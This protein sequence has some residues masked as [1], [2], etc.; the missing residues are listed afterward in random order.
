MTTQKDKTNGYPHD[1]DEIWRMANAKVEGI[2]LSEILEIKN[3]PPEP[4]DIVLVLNPDAFIDLENSPEEFHTLSE[5][6]THKRRARAT[7]RRNQ[8]LIINNNEGIMPEHVHNTNAEFDLRYLEKNTIKLEPHLCTCIDLK[9]ALKI[10]ATIMVQ[11][12][13]RSS[14]AKKRINIRGEIINAGY[15]GNIIAM[16][17]NDS[18]K[19]YVI[20]PNK[21]IAQAIFLSLVKIA[22][23][24]LVG[25]RKELGITAKGI[26]RFGSMGRIE[27]PVNMVEEKIIGQGEIISTG[28]TI[29]IPPYSQYM[30]A[31]E[32]RE[33]KQEQIF[34]AE[35]TLCESREIGLINLHI[36]AKSHNHIKI[37]IYNNTGNIVEIL[38]GTTFEY[39]TT[40]IENQAPSSIPDF[41]QLCEYVDITLQTIYRRNEC[42]LLQPKQL[43]Q[44]NM[45]N[46]DP[47]Q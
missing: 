31:I 6:S 35:A 10:L 38:K 47:L 9:I 14:L 13:S 32:R 22:Q 16:L 23:L 4:T 33:K 8:H 21:R 25:N 36:P 30:L 28:Q 24:V 46:L 3:N 45:R 5:F 7:L 15:V 26:Q 34:E 42:Y 11:L 2:S 19:A 17:Q 44:M 41:S 40:E 20:K 43:K 1:E 29:S 39:L 37:P 18:E 12:A 27:V